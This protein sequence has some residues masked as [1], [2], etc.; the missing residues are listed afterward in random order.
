MIAYFLLGSHWPTRRL[1]CWNFSE[2]SPMCIRNI[3]DRLSKSQS[4]GWTKFTLQNI[5]IGGGRLAHALLDICVILLHLPAHWAVS[6]VDYS[7]KGKSL[8]GTQGSKSKRPGERRGLRPMSGFWKV[9][10]ANSET[11]FVVK[12]V[13]EIPFGQSHAHSQNQVLWSFE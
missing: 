13:W 1:C 5:D 9:S 6:V 10:L 7:D 8:L 3:Q 2:P 11:N 12:R 4:L